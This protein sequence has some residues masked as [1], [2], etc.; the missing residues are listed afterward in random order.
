[1]PPRRA[2][3]MPL[4]REQEKLALENR[5]LFSYFTCF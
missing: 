1:L 2:T 4:R 3:E 5:V